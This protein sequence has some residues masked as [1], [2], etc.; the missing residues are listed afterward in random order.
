MEQMELEGVLTSDA[1]G[2]AS[3]TTPAVALMQIQIE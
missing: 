3:W 2:L 1:A